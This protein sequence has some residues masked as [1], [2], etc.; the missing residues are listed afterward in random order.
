[1]GIDI[2]AG[3]ELAIE[4]IN[5]N[6][7]VLGRPLELVMADTKATSAEDCALAAQVMDKA[8]VVAYFPGAFF[9]AACIDEFG[10]RKAPMQHMSAS[11][12]DIDAVAKG[13]YTNVFQDCASEEV[14]GPNA[15]DVM[16]KSL[17]YT[18]PNNKVALLGGDI[19]YDMYIQKAARKAFEAAGWQVILD[20]TYPYGTT[21]FGPQ[22]AKIRAENPAVIMGIL[23]S[24]DSSVAFMNQFLQNPTNSL[25]F[26]QWSPASPEF[27]NLLK[28]KANGV[29]W[30]T[31]IAGLDTPE[32]TQ[33]VEKFKAKFGREPG[34]TWP[35]GQHDMIYIW[36][37]AVES[38]G[39][40]E[41]YDCVNQYIRDLSQHPYK[42]LNGTYGMNP[43]TYEGLAGDEWLPLQFI[44]I[45]D[46]K[47]VTIA[48]GSKP[49]TGTQFQLPPWIKQ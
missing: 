7:G 34:A 4:E 35:S 33:F 18:F 43:D 47:N 48:L 25:I 40:P 36:K 12:D 30:E 10:K 28:E 49:V 23:T 19:T 44:Q 11:K 13:G 37:T 22:L 17:G 8:G 45:Q 38:C 3:A 24:T 15:F 20:D 29:L 46:Q 1:M 39:D 9:G 14:Y 16:T 21:E 31:L 27:I 5:A 6:G 26:I 42:G 41:A 32:Y 2:Q